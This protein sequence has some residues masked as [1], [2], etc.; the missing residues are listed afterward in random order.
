MPLLLLLACT[1]A[2][3]TPGAASARSPTPA[4]THAAETRAAE[5]GPVPAPASQ[6]V[7]ARVVAL[8]DVHGDPDAALAA[9]RLAGLV[10]TAGAWI[11]G[12][13]WLVQTGDVTDRGPDSRGVIALLRR[14]REEAAAAGG[15]V[16]P[17]LGNH[18]VMN[19]QGAWSYVSPA[20]VQGYG[21]EAARRAAFAPDGEDG[22]YLRALDAVARVGDTVFAHGGVDARH[23]ELGVEK[24]NAAVRAAI[25][26]PD[27]LG[28]LR[29]DGPLWFRGYLLSEPTVACA[30][31]GRALAA[32]GARRMVVGHT[33]QRDGRIAE[34]CDG[35]LYGIDT[36]ISSLYGGNLSALEIR[37]ATVRPL[38]P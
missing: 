8:G 7:P 19:L 29:E 20:D 36:G 5:P 26:G 16:V 4:E 32:L 18:E 14:L 1:G 9:L 6:D 27:R 30:E 24:L 28:V 37:G 35:R 22:A 31:L 17:L 11:G 3:T 33:T 2:P 13:A 38:A 21:G 34:R 25:D 15:R 10:D 23:A 12:E